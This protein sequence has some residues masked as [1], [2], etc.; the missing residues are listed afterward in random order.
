MSKIVDV[1]LKV[2]DDHSRGNTIR[3]TYPPQDTCKYQGCYKGY[4]HDIRE[5]LEEAVKPF[6][7][8][9][10]W[11][12]KPTKCIKCDTPMG[13]LYVVNNQVYRKV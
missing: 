12:G 4:P 2:I 13:E 11:M 3:P 5:E 6:I 1:I 9:H 8:Q 7:C 10:E